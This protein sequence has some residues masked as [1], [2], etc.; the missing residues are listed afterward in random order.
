MV[1][2]TTTIDLLEVRLHVAATSLRFFPT[3]TNLKCVLQP[4][5]SNQAVNLQLS[6]QEKK[7]GSEIILNQMPGNVLVVR[8]WQSVELKR[9]V[10][11]ANSEC[12]R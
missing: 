3:G 4:A 2:F 6:H 10:L 8:H 5:I 7:R 9:Q 11:F 12:E 1:G